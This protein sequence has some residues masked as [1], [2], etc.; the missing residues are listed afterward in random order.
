LLAE[1]HQLSQSLDRFGLAPPE[2]HLWV[3][4]LSKGPFLIANLNQSAA[5]IT[6]EVR[7]ESD[8]AGILKIQ[9]DNFNAFPIFK[10]AFP[11]LEIDPKADLRRHL[12]GNA[13]NDATRA[14]LIRE[15]ISHPLAPSADKSA[16]NL[17]QLL[18]FSAE[19]R[20]LLGDALLDSPALAR[21]IEI[22]LRP[23]AIQSQQ[24]LDGITQALLGAI[25]R[26][27]NAKRA[28]LVL[29][30]ELN[31]K[32]AIDTGDIPLMLDV[33]REPTDDFIRIAH[34][35]TGAFYSSALLR[36]KADPPDGVCSITGQYDALERNNLPSPKLPS[37][38]NTIIF[39]AFDQIPCLA[40]YNLIGSDIFPIGREI[41]QKLNNAAL[42]VTD[43][44]RKGKTWSSIP[45]T[46]DSGRD[47]ILAYVDLHPDLDAEVAALLSESDTTEREGAFEAKAATLI[48]ALDRLRGKLATG[49]ILHS[50]VLS[51]ISKGQV[52]VELTRQFSVER[53]AG[54]LREWA[55][56]AANVP[57]FSIMVPTGKGQPP[58]LIKPRALFPAEVI[59]ATKWIWIRGGAE[60]QPAAAVPLSA[61]YDL[62]LGQG[63]A[64]ET[65]AHAIIGHLL[66]KS[67]PLLL[68]TGD[69][70]TRA[71]K[72]VQKLNVPSRY[73]AVDAFAILGVALYKLNRKTET[74]MSQ[75]AFQLGRMLSLAD[76]LHAQYCQAVRG[77]DLP[78]QL[79]GNQ[80]YS[81]ATENPQRALAVLADRLRIYQG[82]AQTARASGELQSPV[83]LARWAVSEMGALAAELHTNLPA[84]F[85]DLDRAEM[86][87]G[88]LA[89]E[90]KA[91]GANA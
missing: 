32:G 65:A 8:A 87:L 41:A 75:S 45:Q 63:P 12:K 73:S 22:L 76:T 88:Y 14:N 42:W 11:I 90:K 64:S 5:V 49:A 52:Q 26:G 62:F 67:T 40:R 68:F 31:K 35:K 89:R 17:A 30:G 4:P 71:G 19:V 58:Q 21:L 7:D 23:G 44:V 91:E 28:Q 82:W 72:T 60:R 54:A 85:K 59:E 53:L 51:R 46:H 74:Y 15:A 13:V 61:V 55:A 36:R 9:K 27:E 6:V 50:F 3:K 38:G 25:E 66:Q 69:Q 79:L 80:H 18:K 86:M 56:A 39:S 48:A 81:M 16:K 78:P 20:D 77:G 70:L 24:F 2:V 43:P 47:L 10:L 57:P 29:V 33:Y 1:L 34:A 83:R 37:L 84:H